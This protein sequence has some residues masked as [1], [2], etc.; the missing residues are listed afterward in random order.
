MIEVTLKEFDELVL[1]KQALDR[2]IENPDFNRIVVGKYFVL[3]F[4]RLCGL[5]KSTNKAVQKDRDIVVEKVAGIGY[6]EGFLK[7]LGT[8]LTGIDNPEQRLE[9]LRQID[10]FNKQ[11]LESVE[12]A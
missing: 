7:Q 6:I 2:L 9:L 5:L 11:E 12:V 3:E 1:D 8:S 10:E 4:E